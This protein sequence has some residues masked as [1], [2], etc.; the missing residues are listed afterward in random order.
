MNSQYQIRVLGL[1]DP[2][3]SDRLA[4]MAVVQHGKADPPCTTLMGSLTDQSALTGVINALVDLRQ[5]VISVELLE[6]PSGH[7]GDQQ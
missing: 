1:L 2:S 6:A 5:T 7:A 3:W 4:G